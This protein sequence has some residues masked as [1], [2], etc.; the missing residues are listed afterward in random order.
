[1]DLI[2]KREEV[3][4]AA[5]PWVQ[6]A[7]LGAVC[8]YINEEGSQLGQTMALHRRKHISLR[9]LTNQIRRGCDQD[10]QAHIAE[11]AENI[12]Q[13]EDFNDYKTVWQR[14]RDI[15]RL[16]AREEGSLFLQMRVG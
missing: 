15:A 10:K 1:M 2:I 4:K 5:A 6:P 7:P 14:A 13:A 8:L 3:V 9:R 12:N 16:W 11:L